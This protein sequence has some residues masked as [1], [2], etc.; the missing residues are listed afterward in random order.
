M[1]KKRNDKVA[2]EDENTKNMESI[3]TKSTSEGTRTNDMSLV[4][5]SADDTE[6]TRQDLVYAELD[7]VSQN[8]K[9]VLK[10]D[11][12]KTEYAEIVYTNDNQQ[13]NAGNEE[14]VTASDRT[15]K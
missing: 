5:E 11:D 8:L 9:P 4:G 6:G 13:T 1:F 10:K 15:L 2:D 7:L 3:E 14:Q 12:D